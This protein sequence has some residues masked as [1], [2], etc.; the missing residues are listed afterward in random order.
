MSD[1]E[2]R[3]AVIGGRGHQSLTPGIGRGAKLVAIA[4]DGCDDEAKKY[5]TAPWAAGAPYFEDWKEMLR[6]AKPEVI[7]LGAQPARNG[8]I[9]IAALK[10]GIHVVT[11][12][13][14]ANTP[15]ELRRLRALTAA[16]PKLHLLTEF[17]MRSAAAFMAAR[18]AVR[19]GKIG[20]VVLV[21]GQ[22]SY[23][24]GASRP[25]FYKSREGYPGTIAFVGCHIIDLA[26]WITGIKYVAALAGAQGNIAKKDY[27]QF[28]DHAIVLLKMANGADAVMHMDY[29]RP[30]A[31][32]THGDDRI[33]V[34]GSMGVIEVRDEKCVLITQDQP[35]TE[36]ATGGHD[37]EAYAELLAT[38]RGGG[39]GIYSTAE[40]LYMAE[41]ILKARKCVD[42]G[43]AQKID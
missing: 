14:I 23:R 7:S 6:K 1:Q 25:D 5:L 32:P 31:A 2:F 10:R 22:K 38:L 42:D 30:A 13:P 18:D 41:V 24:F 3:V 12:K 35:P 20:D 39:R 8:P 40:S 4:A 34:A 9:I 29:L 26:H 19:S 36:L 33:R 43:K 11:D 17:T 27:G 37:R 21:T 15:A 28:E 16:N